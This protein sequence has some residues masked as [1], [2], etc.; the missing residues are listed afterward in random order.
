MKYAD[1]I[2]PLPLQDCYTYII[3][4]EIGDKVQAGCRVAV[5]FGQRKTYIGIVSEVHVRSPKGYTVKPIS[6]L[7]DS[8]CV[9]TQKQ[10][11]FW[12]WISKYYICTLGDV[13]NAAMPAG[14]KDDDFRPR[15]EIL[16]CL[17]VK[18]D[19]SKVDIILNFLKKS[20][21]QQILFETYL[22]M[23]G[24]NRLKTLKPVSKVELMR[25]C[26]ATHAAFN[27]LV[28][29]KLLVTYEHEI[30]RLNLDEFDVNPLNP[31]N[32]VQQKAFDEINCC[33]EN[34]N[35][36]LLHG[37]TSSGKTEIYIHLI[38]R[39]VNE[40]KQVLYLLPE[41]AL[42]TQITERLRSVFG[43]I[44]GV[45]HS[46]F[47]DAERVEIY[48]KQLSD[49]PFDII[50][51]VRSSI[52]LPYSNLGLVIVDEE[53]ETSYKQQEP[54]PRYHARNGAIILAK[55]FN[56]KTLLGTATPSFETYQLSQTG[57]YGYVSLTQR[58]LNMQLPEIQIIDIKRLQ[59]QK[60]MVG[61]FSKDLLDSIGESLDRNEQVILFQNRRGY[62]NFIQCKTCGWV[63]RCE[64]CDVSL[65]YH[66]NHN[67]LVCHYCGKTYGLPDK[68]PLCEDGNFVN[69]GVGT[70]QIE[71][72]VHKYFPNA[73][74]IRMDIYTAHT[75]TAYEQIISDFSNHQYDILIGTQMVTKG[76]DFDNVSVVGVLDADT[77]LNIP[78]FRSH[79][80]TYHVLAQVAGRAGRRNRKGKVILQTRSA[81]SKTISYVVDNN[82]EAMFKMQ[83]EERELFHYPPYYRLINVY[84][85]HRDSIRVD[86]LACDMARMLRQPFGER[87]LGPDRPSVSRVQSLNIRKLIIKLEKN[88][89][90][91]KIRN[92]LMNIQSQL[93]QQPSANGL[94][95]YYDVDPV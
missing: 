22:E 20:K 75:R 6:K 1:V 50:L 55:Q 49:K 54:A 37:V 44:M 81:D 16:V 4:D 82:Y 9:V 51:G 35:V 41:I 47:S 88:A 63:P 32:D 60:R 38:Q 95:I 29:K 64:H 14:L 76:L 40:G 83:M 80:R 48:R 52:F 94:Q 26:G 93:M 71:S 72:Q 24:F 66:K 92:I 79:E 42:T 61:S 68:C 43:G 13:F 27:G 39:A 77:M 19:P 21:K 59:F 45:Y 91:T 56:A 18:L 90:L 86:M 87:V 23:S 62:S 28:E 33:F 15:V 89:S 10:L 85:R 34:K 36:V 30:G 78:D 2:I 74:A 73:R 69:I 65:T 12:S 3:P 8:R 25:M 46:K 5:P 67:Q 84:L 53:H 57:K 11:D 58:Y 7:L 70:E 17:A 31:L